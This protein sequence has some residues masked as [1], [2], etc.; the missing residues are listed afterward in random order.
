MVRCNRPVHTSLDAGKEVL[1]LENRRERDRGKV[2]DAPV[3]FLDV[4]RI[5][6][7]LFEISVVEEW[8]EGGPG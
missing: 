6:L 2:D 4:G 1:L 7:M 3:L 8:E 5:S